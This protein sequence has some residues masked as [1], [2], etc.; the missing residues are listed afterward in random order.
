MECIIMKTTLPLLALA[1]SVSL[2]LNACGG[3]DTSTSSA[4]TGTLNVVM[5]DAPS[6]GFDHVYVTVNRVRIHSSDSANETADGWQDIVL[7]LPLRIDLLSLTNGVL[8]HLGQTPLPIGHYQQVRLMLDANSSTHPLANSIV[9]T[10]GSEQPLDTPSAMQSGIK[11]IHAFT[12]HADSLT[13]LV[14]DFDACR[15]IMQRGNGS[16]G[17]Q[18]V[19]TATP[20]AVS[21]AITGYVQPSE[22]GAMVYAEQNGVIIKGTV[23]DSNG[24][25]VLAPVLQSSSSANYDVVIVQH[26]YA[27]GIVRAV[28]VSAGASTD[29]STLAAPI[30]LPASSMHAASQALT[31]ASSQVTVYAQQLVKSN[32]YTTALVNANVDTGVWGL[33]LAAGAPL[34]A[35]YSTT[36]PL[37]FTVD[38]SAAG[39]YTLK[40]VTAAGTT[41]TGW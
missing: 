28:P 40:A 32:I 14:L 29:I 31:P 6:C 13:D 35:D 12:V 30:A 39:L 19:V 38:T 18:P 1:L 26:N 15:S 33:N 41:L 4:K 2:L 25:F 3:S 27:T 37:V 34:L 8:L 22:A 21:G 7:P 36:L 24:R 11:I 17:L 10:G 9:P 20:M 5:T 16:Y 23:A